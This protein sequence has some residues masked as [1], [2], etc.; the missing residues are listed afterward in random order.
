MNELGIWLSIAGI[1]FATVLTRATFLLVGNDVRLSPIAQSAL[2]HAP[3]CALAAIV[4]PEMLVSGG[5]LD[6]SLANPRLAAGVVATG[7][8]VLTRGTL[9]TI[10]AGMS[11]FWLWRWL[12]EA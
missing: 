11:A 9:S 3:A 8:C 12:L 1:T 7:V 4:V 5:G 6:L 2:R 10:A